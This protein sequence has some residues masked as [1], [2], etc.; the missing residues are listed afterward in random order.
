MELLAETSSDV[1]VLEDLGRLCMDRQKFD[2]ASL[3]HHA[4]VAT[5]IQNAHYRNSLAMSLVMSGLPEQAGPH[6][7]E[8]A[9]LAPTTPMYLANLGKLRMM[10]KRWTEAHE[11]LERA[12]AL[13]NG[14]S[15][16]KFS[17]LLRICRDNLGAGEPGALNAA[18]TP[19]DRPD[20]AATEASPPRAAAAPAPSPG[21]TL[22]SAIGGAPLPL[23]TTSGGPAK[24]SPSSRRYRLAF[25]SSANMDSFLGPIVD[26]FS[27]RH[28]V[29]KV[30]V[31]DA[32]Q[33]T[34]AMS[35]ADLCWFEWCNEP[36]IYATSLPKS[37]KIVCRLHR[38]EAFTNMPQAVQWEKVD[39]LLGACNSYV[40]KALRQQ[41]PDLDKKVMV[42]QV[43]NGID[44]DRYK[45]VER[46]RGKDIACVGYLHP[47]KN[48][49]FLLHCFKALLD[50]DPG[51]RLHFAGTY[52]D[53]ALQQ[54][55]DY[56]V[57]RLG[58]SQAVVF[59]GWQKDVFA[60]LGDK[61]Y[62]VSASIGEGHPFNIS[63]ALATGLKPAIHNFPGAEE[64]YPPEF[65]FNTVEE[66][67]RIMLEREYDPRQY[68]QFVESRYS[69]EEWGNNVGQLFTLLLEGGVA[70]AGPDLPKAPAW[71][72][73][74][75][76][77]PDQVR[78]NWLI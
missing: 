67:C 3:I 6:L 33:V 16:Q 73:G 27:R 35:W 41:V 24:I 4:L 54:Y 69:L 21:K 11:L 52:Q 2:E 13:G 53:P 32:A 78:A 17:E 42:R 20:P 43:L 9:A 59:A 12:L 77:D 51:F 71:P 40:L 30:V 37:C 28:E 19:V 75:A 39:L 38:Y 45:L 64:L 8:A 68:R 70:D 76:P 55:I 50:Q 60:W 31:T 48:P 72:A 66:F 47:R 58:L 65:L 62:I 10:Q 15:T 29:R 63:E 34:E 22:S 18:P 14:G 26:Y 46:A 56:M 7:E 25:L 44:I 57:D 74:P 23:K 5:D 61:H 36:L 1:G 49:M